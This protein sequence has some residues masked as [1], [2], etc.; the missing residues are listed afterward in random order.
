M[1]NISKEDLTA[2]KQFMSRYELSPIV[3]VEEDENGIV[4]AK[5]ASGQPIMMMNRIDWIEICKYAE[6]KK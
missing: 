3:S 1:N 4:T 6:E 5:S 2:I